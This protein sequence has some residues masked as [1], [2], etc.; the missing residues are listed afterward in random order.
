ME[1]PVNRRKVASWLFRNAPWSLA[2]GI[3]RKMF[4]VAAS[5][6]PKLESEPTSHALITISGNAQ[7]MMRSLG[8]EAPSFKIHK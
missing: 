4:K 3:A 8:V 2:P 5:L 1:E 7:Q 6:T